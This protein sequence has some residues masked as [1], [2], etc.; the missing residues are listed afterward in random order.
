MRINGA[1]D[2]HYHYE[3][4]MFP[5][6]KMIDAMDSNGIKKVA[7]AAR[8]CEPFY[9]DTDFKI[10]STKALR[11]LLSQQDP[12]GYTLYESTIDPEG[13]FTLDP[14]SDEEVYKIYAQ[15]D[16]K[17]VIDVMDR[18]PDRFYGWVFVNPAGP[19]DPMDEI[20]KYISNPNM[21]GVKTHPWWHQYPVKKLEK[22]A[23]WCEKNNYPIQVHLGIGKMGDYKYLP[24]K[25][26]NLKIIYLHAGVPFFK[27]LWHYFKVNKDKYPDVYLDLSSPYVDEY[28][29][30]DAIDSF[31]VDNCLYGTDGPYGYQK[32][33]EDY[34]YGLIKG[35]IENLPILQDDKE[36][37]LYKNF[38]KLIKR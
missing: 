8:M 38:E 14:T 5:L 34:D 26:P 9:L 6:D 11:S 28:I 30:K 27:E 21:I 12:V 31:G 16:N 4:D 32:K 29:I 10:E 18:Y 24:E 22:V 17:E 37:I 25:F 13:N 33:G 1:I 23:E 15:P 19:R 35:W 20:D 2:D 3:P 7:L 36:K